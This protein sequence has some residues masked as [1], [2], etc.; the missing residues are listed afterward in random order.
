[1]ITKRTMIGTY[2]ILGLFAAVALAPV[3]GIVVMALTPPAESSATFSIPSQLDFSN[4]VS[5][6]TTGQFSLYLQ[7]SV[8]VTVSVVVV[9]SIISILSAYA[10]ASFRFYGRTILFYVLLTGLLVP[11]E[12]YVVPLYFEMQSLG[13]TDT[14]LALILP[15]IAQSVAFGTFWMRTF[16]QEIP[17]DLTEAAELDGA[18]RRI[19]LWRILVPVS[20]PAIISMVMLVFMWTWNDFLLALIMI[21]SNS[22]RTAPL[23]LSFFQGSHLTQYSLLAAAATIVALPLVILYAILQRYFIR[24][25]LAGAV[26]G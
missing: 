15:Q 25:M 22:K 13:L 21:S 20:R 19:V 7:S 9:S 3:L 16:F 14:Y 5:A 1:M 18:S 24:G 8:I 6:W 2:G 26:K 4:F 12:T 10:F 17:R 11:I 23:A